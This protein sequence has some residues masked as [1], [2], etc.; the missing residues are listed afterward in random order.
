MDRPKQD[1]SE[2]NDVIHFHRELDPIKD[3]TV[4]LNHSVAKVV[5][6]FRAEREETNR[7]ISDINQLAKDMKA[8]L[9]L[10]KLPES[11]D[12]QTN[13][14]VDHALNDFSNTARAFPA[15]NAEEYVV[16]ILA[17]F[18]SV[19]IDII[20]VG[21]PE[22]VKLYRGGENFD[23]SLL[24][25]VL[26]KVGKNQNGE[27][28]SVL[29]WFSDVCKVPYDISAW[30]GVVNPNNHRLRSFAH[31]P[32]LGL[33]F[34]VADILCGT[35]TCIDNEGHLRILISPKEVSTTEKFL[36]VFYYLGHIISDLCTTRGIPV[37]GFCLTQF[38]TN[39]TSDNSIAK[40]AERMYLDGYDLRHLVSTTVPVVVKNLIVEA[41]LFLNKDQTEIFLPVMEK[42]RQALNRQLKREKM[43]FV[44]NLTASTGNVI[45]FL[46]PPNCGNPC[47]LNLAQWFELV[48]N[49]CS[50][51][52][53]AT[54]DRTAETVM[55]N[56]EA[57]QKNWDILLSGD[58]PPNSI[59]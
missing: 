39:G 37:P 14:A 6:E 31:D 43:L 1:K 45:K 30:T 36:A 20:F 41:Y 17:G 13:E 51:L 47:A 56:R 8:D 42:E 11:G 58:K 46:S 22:V 34:A 16:A 28:P 15:L 19:M 55:A 38:F 53:A 24:T 27:M 21:T 52:R 33:F 44:A 57:V 54:R 50:M 59:S 7:L 35:T 40:I 9:V 25:S 2:R 18:V 4:Q 32:F 26:R 3:S 48:K 12:F 29:Q 49:S 5:E 23:G 10:S